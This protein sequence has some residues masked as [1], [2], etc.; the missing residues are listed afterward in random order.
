M[1]NKEID[2][3]IVAGNFPEAGCKPEL[4]ETHISW[5]ILCENYVYKI[6]KP[7]FYHFIDFSTIGKRKYY[8]DREVSLNKRLANDIYI[9]VVPVKNGSG[10]LFVGDDVGEVVDYAVRMRKLDRQTQMDYLLRN[11]GITITDMELLA[12]KIIAFH[13]STEI[14]FQKDVL[15]IRQKFNDLG[16]E[17]DFLQRHFGLEAEA[18]IIHAVDV[19]DYYLRNNQAL[20]T[21]RL[22]EGF[23]RDCHGDLHAKNIFLV[24]GSPQFFDCIEFN[25]DYRQVDVLNEIAFLCMDLD[26]F[27]REDLADYFLKYYNK[28][29]P[30]MRN[31]DEKMLFFY[32]KSYRANIMAKINSL[33]AKSTENEMLQKPLLKEAKKYLELMNR[34]LKMIE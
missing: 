6:K 25:D 8:C 22:Y 10:K 1:T 24:P 29:F 30:V 16:F 33:R 14:I 15:D 5:V 9:D 18:L 4:I 34:Y 7:V 17:K 12:K 11:G 31:K 3:L 20:L 2:K 27:G 23:F 21:T 26:A 13:N 19:S 32:Y 28:L